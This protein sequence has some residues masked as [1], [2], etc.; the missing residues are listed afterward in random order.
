MKEKQKINKVKSRDI[1]R[2]IDR[3]EKAKSIIGKCN[4]IANSLECDKKENNG[5]GSFEKLIHAIYYLDDTL[6]CLEQSI[7]YLKEAVQQKQK[8]NKKKYFFQK[9]Y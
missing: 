6:I 5:D 7:E 3:L 1:L 2:I 9:K 8:K 4:G